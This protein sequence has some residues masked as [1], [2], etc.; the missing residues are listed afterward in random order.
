M[1]TQLFG[2][3]LILC[4]ILVDNQDICTVLYTTCQLQVGVHDV[5]YATDQLAIGTQETR[6]ALDPSRGQGVN[7]R[8]F[9]FKYVA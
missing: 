5:R 9:H 8:V 4:R 7:G 2:T 3:N 1:K 6:Q